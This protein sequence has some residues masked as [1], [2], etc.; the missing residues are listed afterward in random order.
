LDSPN[1]FAYPT[2]TARNGTTVIIYTRNAGGKFPI[3]GAYYAG[4]D[5]WIPLAWTINGKIIT[6]NN[7]PLDIDVSLSHYDANKTAEG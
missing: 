7:S 6:V 4:R 2:L 1:G 3:H 5:E